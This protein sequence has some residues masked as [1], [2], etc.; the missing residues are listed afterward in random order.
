MTGEL[1]QLF[2][3]GLVGVSNT[4]ITITVYAVLTRVGVPAPVASTTGFAAGAANGY[5]L[6]RNWTFRGA[7]GGARTVARYAA[8]QLLGAA[9]SGV[10][11]ALATS[12]LQLRHLAAEVL[13]LPAV[14]LIT[15]ALSSRLVFGR[16]ALA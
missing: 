13:V 12:D 11:V 6:N 7:R 1:G 9:L 4:L 8:V 10:G 2:R 14:T 5:R 16:A 3:F 15:Y